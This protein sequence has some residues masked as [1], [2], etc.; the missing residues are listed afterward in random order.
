MK[1]VRALFVALVAIVTMAPATAYAGSGGS[2][3]VTSP[4]GS[5]SVRVPGSGGSGPG[6]GPNGSYGNGSSNGGRGNGRDSSGPSRPSNTIYVIVRPGDPAWGAR[7]YCI[8]PDRLARFVCYVAY[9]PGQPPRPRPP[10]RCTVQYG[11][12]FRFVD[13]RGNSIT[14]SSTLDAPNCESRSR[15]ESI[16]CAPGSPFRYEIFG[17]VSVG[18]RQGD[19]GTMN[20]LGP[21]VWSA[22]AGI[23]WPCQPPV[24]DCST[25]ALC[26]GYVL[27]DH[28]EMKV[29]VPE[30]A[31]RSGAGLRGDGS[32]LAAVRVVTGRLICRGTRLGVW[33]EEP[34]PANNPRVNSIRVPA[35]RIT[36]PSGHRYR[37][38]KPW[39]WNG[40][41]GEMRLGFWT[42]SKT[43]QRYRVDLLGASAT[44]RAQDGSGAWHVHPL[45][46]KVIYTDG[47]QTFRVI[48]ATTDPRTLG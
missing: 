47:R 6:G 44:Q 35:P 46:V 17:Y 41:A 19:K 5:V 26:N 43:N 36:A 18:A 30:A 42:T 48:D 7:G 29:T 37:V 11:F 25:P 45:A 24:P 3:S 12:R 32:D 27:A 20:N 15:A 34:C 38:I 28:L 1:S 40:L 10:V 23:S 4:G 21:M 13:T 8:G 9:R 33:V 16:V 14:R 22:E 39:H 2:G 31:M